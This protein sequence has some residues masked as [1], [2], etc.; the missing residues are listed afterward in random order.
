MPELFLHFSIPFALVA[1]IL[2]LKRALLAGF[3]AILPDI[4]A[5]MH[6]H[7]SLTHSI[8]FLSIR[9]AIFILASWKAARGLHTVTACSLSL[10]HD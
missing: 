1:P 9:S 8:L 2:G 7:R 4:D 6:V 10:L 5:L 3:I